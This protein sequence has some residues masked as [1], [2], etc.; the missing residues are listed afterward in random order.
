MK[1]I[2]AWVF[3]PTKKIEDEL[4]FQSQVIVRGL[5]NPRYVRS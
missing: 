4:K 1:N 5:E 3:Q 2:V